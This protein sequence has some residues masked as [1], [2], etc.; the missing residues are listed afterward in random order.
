M[1]RY[2]PTIDTLFNQMWNQHRPELAD[3]LLAENFKAYYSDEVVSTHDAFKAM[4]MDWFTGIPDIKHDVLDYFEQGD[5]V[6][7]RWT[8]YGKH[9]GEF[10]GLA[11]TGKPFHYSGITIF[12]L[13]DT[14]KI[15][16]A[17]IAM[18]FAEQFAKL[19]Q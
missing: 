2:H 4:L 3:E 7:A 19:S 15:S 6:V 16:Q 14:G 5:R 13:D 8:G 1:Q 12:Q 18:D 10:S 9:T 17:W 11:A